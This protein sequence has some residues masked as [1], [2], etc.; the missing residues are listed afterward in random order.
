MRKLTRGDLI[1]VFQQIHSYF[2]MKQDPYGQKGGF[3]GDDL[4]SSS[5]PYKLEMGK[6]RTFS[7][8]GLYSFR[9]VAM[10]RIGMMLKRT[11]KCVSSVEISTTPLCDILIMVDIIAISHICRVIKQDSDYCSSLHISSLTNMSF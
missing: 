11:Q 2:M 10:D 5:V 9:E 8:L 7:S 4:S 1:R 6:L 3:G